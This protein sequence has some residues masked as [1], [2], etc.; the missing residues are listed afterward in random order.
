MNHPNIIKIYE[1]FENKKFIFIVLEYANYGDLL[2]YLK[3]HGKFSQQNFIPIFKQ[4]LK[5]LYYM[6]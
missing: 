6:H 4:I 2:S 5:G 1:I 3:N